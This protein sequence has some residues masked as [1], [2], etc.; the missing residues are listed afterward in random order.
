M[1]KKVINNKNTLTKIIYDDILDETT[2][3][4][5]IEK[6][7]D[8]EYNLIT[9]NSTILLTILNNTEKKEVGIKYNGDKYLFPGAE[10]DLVEFN[11]VEY[12]EK[13]GLYSL[14]IIY[15]HKALENEEHEN[16][17]LENEKLEKEELEKATKIHFAIS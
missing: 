2:P 3:V 9:E 6:I 13:N 1:N 16:E 5:K 8:N 4:T 15:K 12:E 7:N 11:N 17:E 10:D 14:D